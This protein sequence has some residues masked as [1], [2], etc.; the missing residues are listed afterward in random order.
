MRKS[1]GFTIIELLVVVVLFLSM[2]GLFLYQKNTIEA[3]ARDDRRKADINTLYHNLEKVYYPAHQSYPDTLATNTL[4]A[5]QADTFKDPAGL[6][7]NELRVDDSLLGTTTRSTYTYEPTS[8][9]NNQCSGY[10]L[11]ADLEK[12]ADYVRTSVHGNKK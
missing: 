6:S 2:C 5:V 4:P 8:C 10:T 12:E 1:A 9:K 3:A 11:R 7:I